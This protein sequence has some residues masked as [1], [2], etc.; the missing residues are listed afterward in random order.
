M[1]VE[2][3]G[4]FELKQRTIGKRREEKKRESREEN[5]GE[6]RREEK[7]RRERA[8]TSC[9]EKVYDKCFFIYIESPIIYT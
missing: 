4:A 6:E 8:E 3:L 1:E 9:N 5:A 2:D 7:R